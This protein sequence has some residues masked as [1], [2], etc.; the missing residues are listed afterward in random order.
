MKAGSTIFL[1]SLFFSI[2]LSAEAGGSHQYGHHGH[3]LTALSKAGSPATATEELRTIKVTAL[4]SMSF[5]HEPLIVSVGETVRFEVVNEGAVT[6]EL[7][8]GTKDEHILHQAEMRAMP[9][10]K[11]SDPNVV[12]V[13]PGETKVLI[14]TFTEARS[15]QIACNI[16]GHYES[17]MFSELKI[18]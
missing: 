18:L 3:E 6:H 4:D 11:H 5:E 8:V 15:A 17:G 2:P 9:S 7:A 14:W 10:M 16:P 13:E 1:L 12:T